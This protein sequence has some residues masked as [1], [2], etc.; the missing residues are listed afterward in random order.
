MAKTHARRSPLSIFFLLCPLLLHAT[1]QLAAE[2]SL[3]QFVLAQW[4]LPRIFQ[5][6]TWMLVC[7]GKEEDRQ[8]QYARIA[9]AIIWEV[10]L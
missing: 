4:I 8:Q 6:F 7:A 5:R 2:H 1:P 9:T 10:H 3:L